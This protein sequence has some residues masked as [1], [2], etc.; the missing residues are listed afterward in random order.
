MAVLATVIAG[1]Y[2]AT[3]NSLALGLM[4]DQGYRLSVSIKEQLINRSDGYAQ[5]LIETVYQGADWRIVM[6]ALEYGA[7]AIA[8]A[9]N[10]FATLGALG[11]ISVLGT[12]VA[13]TLVLTSTVGTPAAAA[14]ATLTATKAKQG[15]NSNTELSFTSAMRTV[16]LSMDLLPET[17]SATV[18][19]FAIT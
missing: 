18:K 12:G 19:H 7:A 10:P 17:V 8:T 1:R 16:P 11:T 13:Q 6:E 15:Q 4:S 9:I 3:W 2:T 14:P 5:T